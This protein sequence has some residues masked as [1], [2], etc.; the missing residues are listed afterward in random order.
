M[1]ER[2]NLLKSEFLQGVSFEF[3]TTLMEINGSSELIR[4][5]LNMDAAETKALATEIYNNGD[6]LDRLITE[7]L[8]L[9]RIETS[10]GSLMVESLDLNVIIAG[11]TSKVKHNMSGALFVVQPRPIVARGGR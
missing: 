5:A 9:D 11:E 10:H 1:L 4:D 7:M 3:R 8:E 2:L 6:R